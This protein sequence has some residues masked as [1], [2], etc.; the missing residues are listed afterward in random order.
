MGILYQTMRALTAISIAILVAVCVADPVAEKI[1]SE[2]RDGKILPIFQVVKFPN[3]VCEG[4]SRNGTCYTSEECSTKGGTSDGSCASG[5]G[6]CCMFALACGGSASEN[7]TYLIQ[8]SVTSLTSP[9]T[10]TICP[11][12]TNICRIRFDFESFVLASA[13]AG[14]TVEGAVTISTLNEAIGDCTTDSFSIT[15]GSGGG[16]TPVICGTN[17][18]Y[19]MIVDSG[20]GETTCHKANFNVGGS[21]STS[22]TWSIRVT[23][24]ACGDYD[25]SGWPGCLQYYTATANTIQNFGFS[26][27]ATAVTSSVT[28]LS[29]QSY[30]IC[31]RRAS[32]MCY[33]CYSPTLGTDAADAAIAQVSFGTSLSS[34]A[35]ILSDVGT[36]CTV[37]WLEI[38]GGDTQAITAIAIAAATNTNRFCGRVFT[39]IDANAIT[40]TICSRQTPFRVGVNFDN[41]EVHT[42]ATADM[43]QLGEQSR[44]PG[45]IIGFKLTYFQRSC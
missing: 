5:F 1:A 27:T 33:I 12:S 32:G 42:A 14:T 35:I 17:T 9:C 8:S 43:A 24:Y 28:H 13:V 19:H 29:E 7:Q 25:S 41:T 6:V 23:Q 38:P 39:V 34:A 21:T 15:G 10:Y 20:P 18:G 11:C 44:F 3:D 31:I 26:P 22:R 4:S 2:T 36:T 45:G 16:G 37:D 30:D 40:I